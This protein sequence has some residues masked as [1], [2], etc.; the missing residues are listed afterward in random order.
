M[1]RYMR[2]TFVGGSTRPS[3]HVRPLS[4][5]ERTTILE[6]NRLGPPAVGGASQLII[7]TKCI[8]PSDPTMQWLSPATLSVAVAPAGRQ[9][10]PRSLLTNR[11]AR[12]PSDDGDPGPST[13]LVAPA[14]AH[15]IRTLGSFGDAETSTSFCT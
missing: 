14:T 10:R 1:R 4:P 7:E 2:S 12:S 6:R 13:M 11:L 9:L 15:V 8:R 3:C 5:D